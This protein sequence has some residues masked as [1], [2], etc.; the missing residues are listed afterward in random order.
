[1]TGQENYR[2]GFYFLRILLFIICSISFGVLN[3]SAFEFNEMLSIHGFLE[4]QTGVRLQD[5]YLG[6]AEDGDFSLM[7]NTLQLEAKGRFSDHISY[8]TK[9]RGWYDAVYDIDSN[10][11]DR[12]ED[13]DDNIWDADLH[14]YFATAQFGNWNVQIGQQELVW[15][16][17]DLFRM[18]DIVNPV[19]LSWHYLWPNLDGDGYRIPLRM[20]VIDYLTNW[21]NFVAQAVVIPEH[22]EPWKL[23]PEGAN[24]FPP[25]LL[26]PGGYDVANTLIDDGHD[27][28]DGDNFEAGLRLKA[29]IAGADASVFYF[30]TRSDL[31]AFNFNPSSL[32]L[33]A[34]FEKYDVVG[35]TL[36]YYEPNTKTVFRFETAFNFDNPYTAF[37]NHPVFGPVPGVVKKDTFAYMVGFDRESFLGW[38][39]GRTVNISGQM[40]QQY[41]LDSDDSVFYPFMAEPD[42]QTM[43]T[44]ILNTFLGFGNKWM[45]QLLVGYDVDGAGVF[46]PSLKYSHS[47]N[48]SMSLNYTAFWGD[49]Q[50]GGYFHPFE[51]ND[52]IWLQVRLKL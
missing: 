33:E 2:S 52:E 34:K 40:F 23:A 12:P 39:K 9:F 8:N 31:P 19:D 29:N 45:P 15:G 27:S 13:D 16:E 41:I 10:I 4:N 26:L 5:H 36:N 7:R 38:P 42:Q 28:S 18:A 25:A 17:S 51:K 22:F 3:S 24:F 30:H 50:N 48:L 11:D 32:A 6:Y 44:L 46:Y 20:V 37:S 1:M 14:T 47:D 35:A 43:F 21:H 49:A